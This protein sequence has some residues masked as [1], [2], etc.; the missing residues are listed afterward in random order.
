MET[1]LYVYGITYTLHRGPFVEQFETT[2]LAEC[3]HEAIEKFD[4]WIE[5]KIAEGNKDDVTYDLLAV[6]PV[7]Q[8]EI[9]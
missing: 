8:I 1:R 7:S 2:T 6:V 3:A 4:V 5:A 9:L